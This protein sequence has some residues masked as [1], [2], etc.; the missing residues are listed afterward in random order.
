MVPFKTTCTAGSGSSKILMSGVVLEYW[1]HDCNINSTID[2]FGLVLIRTCPH[3]FCDRRSAAEFPSRISLLQSR[4]PLLPPPPPHHLDLVL[5][6]S[7]SSQQETA[8]KTTGNNSVLNHVADVRKMFTQ[9]NLHIYL[10]KS[11]EHKVPRISG[12]SVRN[13]LQY[14]ALLFIWIQ[15]Y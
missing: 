1:L 6:H 4:H 7:C 9:L 2:I 15:K 8:N 3:M 5:S 10:H 12:R 13:T 14:Q 11:Q